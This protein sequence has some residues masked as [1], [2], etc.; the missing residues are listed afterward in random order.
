MVGK[1]VAVEEWNTR[2]AK[3]PLSEIKAWAYAV[4]RAY[5]GARSQEA[6]LFFADWTLELSFAYLDER[7][8]WDRF[9]PECPASGDR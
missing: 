8:D 5:K 1:S 7:V 9:F 2:K 4:S 3:A 6:R